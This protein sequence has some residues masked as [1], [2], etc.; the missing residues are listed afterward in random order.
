M[1]G[2]VKARQ[3]MALVL[4]RQWDVVGG[5]YDHSDGVL[6]GGRSGS[7]KTMLARMMCEL[8]DLP[9][10][11]VNATRYT[12]AGYAGLDLAQM[13]LPLLE[14]SARI[15]DAR[16]AARREASTS[17]FVRNAPANTIAEVLERP[18]FDEILEIAE[19]GVI[20][21]D[22]IDKWMLRLNHVTGQQD[23]AIQ[24][25]LLKIIEGSHEFVSDN[26]DEVGIMFDSTKVLIICAG[27][28]VKL[29]SQVAAR[30]EKQ[31]HDESIWD[32]IDQQDLVNYGILPE[33]A[34]RLAVHIFLRPL[35]IE[36]MTELL[37]AERGPLEEYRR[38]F[39]D[40]GIAWAVSDSGTRDLAALAMRAE[41]GARAIDYVLHRVFSTALYRAHSE[42]GTAVVYEPMM[43][44]ARIV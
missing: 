7:G 20:L 37:V 29:Q 40:A 24:A 17:A 32:Q 14:A 9:F 31:L 12:E 42:S 44:E 28:F 13:F 43:A 18:D 39:A 11:E 38:R 36:H 1:R 4:A 19:S 5:E 2:Q 25:D 23:T 22:E 21:L 35:K 33:L 8:S 30:L 3:Q 16:D 34:G 15:K 27:A 10:A 41:T 6:I 26:N